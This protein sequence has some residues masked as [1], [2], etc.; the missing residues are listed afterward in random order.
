MTSRRSSQIYVG[1]RLG[2]RKVSHL[3]SETAWHRR[4]L[5]SSIVP[6]DGFFAWTRDKGD[7]RSIWFYRHDGGLVFFAGLADDAGTFAIVLGG[8]SRP[9][10]RSTIGSP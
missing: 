7:K 1:L 9:V 3:R 6:A 4:D 10:L 8:A 5:L 2:P